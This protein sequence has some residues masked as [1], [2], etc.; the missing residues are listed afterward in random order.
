MCGLT[1]DLIKARGL[2]EFI[3]WNEFVIIVENNEDISRF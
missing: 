3:V 2:L 1:T